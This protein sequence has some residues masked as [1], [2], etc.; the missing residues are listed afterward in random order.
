[1]HP[2]SVRG[3]PEQLTIDTGGGPIVV[4]RTEWAQPAPAASGAPEAK[5]EA[6]DDHSPTAPSLAHPPTHP[7][8]HR[9]SLSHTHPPLTA[10]PTH[11]LS[12]PHPPAAPPR[13]VRRAAPAR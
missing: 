3:L 11:S 1:M 5:E 4:A 12:R 6:R 8:T 9:L 7:L 10:S 13:L 2:P